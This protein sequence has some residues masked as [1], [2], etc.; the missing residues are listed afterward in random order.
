MTFFCLEWIENFCLQMQLVY[1][2][3]YYVFRKFKLQ[4]IS[5]GSSCKNKQKIHPGE[6]TMLAG[7]LELLYEADVC[8][9]LNLS[10]LELRLFE[11]MNLGK[12]R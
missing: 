2:L 5:P 12:F 9:F 6:R 1:Y 11:A 7:S 4:D 8:M 10:R 3:N